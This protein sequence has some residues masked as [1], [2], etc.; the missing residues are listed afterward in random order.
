[1]QSELMK[2]SRVS[3]CA[4]EQTDPIP[5]SSHLLC[6]KSSVLILC[7]WQQNLTLLSQKYSLKMYLSEKK[8]EKTRS[9]H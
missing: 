5:F 7:N 9:I 8:P 2:T 1:M 4:K 3:D 6:K